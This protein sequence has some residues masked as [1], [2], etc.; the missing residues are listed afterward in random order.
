MRYGS[1]L[2][3][4]VEK[5]TS[6]KQGGRKGGTKLKRNSVEARRR[7]K[8][9]GKQLQEKEHKGTTLTRR[10]RSNCQPGVKRQGVI[11]AH[12]YVRFEGDR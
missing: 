4:S 6:S 3:L 10:D 8:R 7:A 2:S 9:G 5:Q 1:Q 11:D 12:P